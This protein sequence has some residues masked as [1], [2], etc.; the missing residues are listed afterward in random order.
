[1]N[2][3]RI[4]LIV[5]IV[6]VVVVAI[7]AVQNANDDSVSTPTPIFI[8]VPPA[9]EDTP[10]VPVISTIPAGYLLAQPPLQYTEI[11]NVGKGWIIND[12]E[13]YFG[14]GFR[15]DV[16][17]IT[18]PGITYISDLNFDDNI[19]E[20]LETF[21]APD[22][23]AIS[24]FEFG[25]FDDGL[26]MTLSAPKLKYIYDEFQLYD[27]EANNLNVTLPV[28]E[29]ANQIYFDNM[30]GFITFSAPVLKTIT[31]Q[32]YAYECA[33]LTTLNVPMATY[34]HEI[35]VE[36]CN[37]LTTLDVS[38]V[39]IINRLYIQ[40]CDALVTFS[41][42]SLTGI[43]GDNSIYLEAAFDVA[44]VDLLLSQLAALD[45]TNGT[46][47]LENQDIYLEGNNASP[48]SSGP[49]S[50]IAILEAR[51]NTVFYN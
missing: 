30:E 40:N 49:G 17:A 37:D 39:E 4:L 31:E 19:F 2:G 16:T 28:L 35:D 26:F 47:I 23:V 42:P 48:T 33:G 22:L 50:S 18:M 20:R 45:G 21:S 46:I 6:V 13:Y 3:I 34:I 25:D 14:S 38:S 11:A 44:T 7:M 43:T 15:Q 1:M 32:F 12:A 8:S 5:L 36:D 10:P 51:G 41:L 24:N 9:E 29:T 27:F